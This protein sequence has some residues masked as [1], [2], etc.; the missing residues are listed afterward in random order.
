MNERKKDLRVNA[1][2]TIKQSVKKAFRD[3]CIKHDVSGS[4]IISDLLENY[5]SEK[6]EV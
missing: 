5:L 4:R 2:F 1:A 6:G 3:Y